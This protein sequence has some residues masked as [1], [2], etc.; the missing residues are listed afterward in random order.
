MDTIESVNEDSS[1]LGRIVAW[2]EAILIAADNPMF[3]GGFKAGQHA[4]I[5]KYGWT[6]RA[7][8]SFNPPCPWLMWRLLA[9]SYQLH[10]FPN[11][12]VKCTAN[13]PYRN[14][15]HFRCMIKKLCTGEIPR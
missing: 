4:I 8:C 7:I 3:G 15:N 2:K 12:T 10:I 5:W 6:A 1:F 9:A 13:H 11:A 14:D